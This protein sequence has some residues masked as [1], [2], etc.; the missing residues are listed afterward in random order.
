[1]NQYLELREYMMYLIIKKNKS[2][3][4]C[5]TNI[6]LFIISKNEMVVV[7]LHWLTAMTMG[8]YTILSMMI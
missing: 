6:S 4:K 1:M 7:Y 5:K 2:K 3:I 8:V